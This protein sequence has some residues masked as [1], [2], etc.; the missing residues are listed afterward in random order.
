MT[1][2]MVDL[3]GT[4]SDHTDRLRVLQATTQ[5]DP[6]DR[7]AWKTYYQGLIDDEPRD[8]VMYVMHEWIKMDIRPLIYSTRFVN[9]Y[10]QE[11]EWLRGHELW[12]HVDL[13]QRLPQETKIKGPDLVCQWV[14][15]YKPTIVVDDRESVRDI[16]RSQHPQVAVMGPEDFTRPAA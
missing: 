10:S 8:N 16:V 9:K 2:I 15:K 12:E 5:M 7:T 14:W 13:I 3:E 4:L 11:E 1:T 6:R